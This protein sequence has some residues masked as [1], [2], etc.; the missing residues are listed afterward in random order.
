MP[1]T[2]LIVV[3]S[4]V[5]CLELFNYQYYNC[6]DTSS[7]TDDIIFKSLYLLHYL[8]NIFFKLPLECISN[9]NFISLS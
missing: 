9:G 6:N 7:L 5:E 8:L 1:E 4:L 2:V 3:W